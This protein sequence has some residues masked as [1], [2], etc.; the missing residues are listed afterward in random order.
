MGEKLFN[1]L[2]VLFFIIGTMAGGVYLYSQIPQAQKVVQ[3]LTTGAG[4]EDRNKI[5]MLGSSS[6]LVSLPSSMVEANATTTD[7]GGSV[8]DGGSTLIQRLD[9]SGIRKVILNISTVGGTA[10]STM[11]IKQMGSF[12]GTSYFNLATSTALFTS[13][14]T[15]PSLTAKGSV[16]VP[17][18][19]TT[20]ISLPFE[21]DGH[22]FT[23]FL[24]Y[25]DNVAGDPN[26]GIQAWIT[27]TLVEDIVR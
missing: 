6:N 22:P 9:T 20:T 8:L 17:G 27:A 15:P 26:D 5:T 1:I 7:S 2:M 11:Y 23:R 13:T 21:V 25:G 14:S 24:F 18:L 19:A 16:I 4:F 3:D 12:D 10:T